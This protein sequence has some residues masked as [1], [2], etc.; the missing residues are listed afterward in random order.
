MGSMPCVRPGNRPGKINQSNRTIMPLLSDTAY[1]ERLHR[2]YPNVPFGELKKA[3]RRY[4][5]EREQ[6]EYL[7]KLNDLN[8]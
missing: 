6:N 5:D 1:L 3:V 2:I 4:K 7:R 8:K